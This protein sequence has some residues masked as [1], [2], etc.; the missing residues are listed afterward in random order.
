MIVGLLTDDMPVPG[1]RSLEDQPML[2]TRLEN[3]LATFN[4]ELLT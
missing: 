3:R 1:S 4:V 2:L